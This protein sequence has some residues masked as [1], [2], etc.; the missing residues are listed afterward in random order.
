[1]RYATRI[2][3]AAAYAAP[4][5]SRILQWSNLYGQPDKAD[6]SSWREFMVEKRRDRREFEP[7]FKL[8][9]VRMVKEQGYTIAQVCDNLDLVDSAVRRWIKQ[10]KSELSGVVGVG[11]PLTPEQHRIREL[12]KEVL[13]LK[14]DNDILKKASAFFAREMK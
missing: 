2:A 5:S 13:R 10:Y 1:M 7:A 11:L 12:E 14:S 4:R 8:E 3:N 9:V 6:Y